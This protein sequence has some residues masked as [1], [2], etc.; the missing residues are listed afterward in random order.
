MPAFRISDF[1]KWTYKLQT[2]FVITSRCEMRTFGLTAN[3]STRNTRGDR[4]CLV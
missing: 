2:E 4:T 3:Y 1:E